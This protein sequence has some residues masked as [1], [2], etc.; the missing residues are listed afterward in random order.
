VEGKNLIKEKYNEQAQQVTIDVKGFLNA[1]LK[2]DIA[3]GGNGA[4]G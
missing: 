2:K 4:P 1:L 3:K